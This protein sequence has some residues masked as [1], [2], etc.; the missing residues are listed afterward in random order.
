MTGDNFTISS[1]VFVKNAKC[2]CGRDLWEVKDEGFSASYPRY[3]YFCTSCD[4]VYEFKLA[5]RPKNKVSESF[6]QKCRKMILG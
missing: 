4:L 2:K 3:V 5:V 1:N 6:I